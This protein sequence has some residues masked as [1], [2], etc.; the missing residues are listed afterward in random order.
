MNRN[1]LLEL[2][3]AGERKKEDRRIGAEYE[4]LLV[5]RKTGLSL[6]W[7]GKYGIE[8]VL[9]F[10]CDHFGWEPYEDEGIIIALRRGDQSITLEPGGQFEMSGAPQKSLND[11]EAEL[12]NHEEEL[13]ALRDSMPVDV[14]WLG[15]NPKQGID[16]VN[17]MPKPRYRTMRRYMP[18]KGK[19]GLAMMGLTCT[20]QSNLDITGEADFAKKMKMGTGVGPLV[21]ALFANSWQFEGQDSGFQS[22]RANVWHHTDPDRS[23]MP[24]FVFDTDCGYEDYVNWVLDVPLYFVKREGKYVDLAGKGTFRDLMAGRVSGHHARPEDWKL[25]MSTVFP[26]VRAR[27]FLEFRQAD[28]V[29]PEGI[30]ALSALWKGIVY[31]DDA[32][33]AAW[34]LVK[35]QSYDQHLQLSRDV[36]R[37]ALGASRPNALGTILPLCKELLDISA[38]GLRR[39]AAAGRG[40]SHDDRHLAV[41]YEI[42]Q[43]GETFATRSRR[44]AF[45]KSP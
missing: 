36:A 5:D 39:E 21:T 7:S 41:L 14:Q 23:G 29:P 34:A 45:T 26:D 30:V 32:C 44:A 38:E 18:L 35:K 1:D 43:S 6:P 40:D 3:P 31:D 8:A 37:D 27:P 42:V 11:V 13:F 17:W 24:R 25:H 15:I 12:K 33:D 9:K 16:Q 22:F 10:F 20:V 2:F 4:K 19:L 28:V